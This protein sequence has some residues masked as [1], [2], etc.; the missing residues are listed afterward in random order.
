MMTSMTIR[1]KMQLLP[2]A[3]AVLTGLQQLDINAL[4]LPPALEA[5][6]GMHLTFQLGA[7]M[8]PFFNGLASENFS[9]LYLAQLCLQACRLGHELCRH[10]RFDTARN[11]VRE[12]TC[13]KAQ[14]PAS[15][16]QVHS[17]CLGSHVRQP[18]QPVCASLCQQCPCILW[19]AERGRQPNGCTHAGCILPI[20]R[21]ASRMARS[22]KVTVTDI[23]TFN[24]PL[25][26]CA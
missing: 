14:C 20:A 26:P 10:T 11:E 25:Q 3:A 15:P 22:C 16:E 7:H 23:Y 5:L 13:G 9:R 2:A 17:Q 19:G 4:T 6:A 18:R 8:R 12:W 1:R 21:A 24:T